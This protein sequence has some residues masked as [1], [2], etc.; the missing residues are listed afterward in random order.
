MKKKFITCQTLG[1][2]W[3]ILKHTQGGSLSEK[4]LKT[5]KYQDI[6][7]T[8]YQHQINIFEHNL[9]IKKK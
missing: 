9:A 6:Y 1:V 7:D 8:N 2:S 4:L 5:K 3:R